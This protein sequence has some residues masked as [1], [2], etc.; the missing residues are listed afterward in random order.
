[1]RADKVMFGTDTPIKIFSEK[2]D[3]PVL[4]I[5]QVFADKDG[6]GG[7]LYLISDD[8]TLTYEQITDICRKRRSAECYHN[9]VEI[10]FLSLKQNASPEK[11]PARVVST[12]KNHFSASLC[13]YVRLG[14][15]KFSGKLNHFALKAEIY[16]SALRSAFLE[17]QK[18]Q[19]LKITA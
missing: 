2:A 19:L 7:I 1:M 15:L 8:M 16:I 9:F 13:G 6:S 3:F 10:H 17:L 11:S 4:L 14:M 5:R 12:Q 18:L